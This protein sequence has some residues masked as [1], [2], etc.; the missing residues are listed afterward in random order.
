MKIT[1]FRLYIY[2]IKCIDVKLRGTY[3]PS[4]RVE[5]QGI[6]M[7]RWIKMCCCEDWKNLP[8]C[9]NEISCYS[10]NQEFHVSIFRCQTKVSTLIE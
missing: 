9:R 3:I 8:S 5:L 1:I 6:F 7:K 10:R 2:I 4:P